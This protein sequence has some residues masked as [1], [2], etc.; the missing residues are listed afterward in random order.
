MSLAIQIVDLIKAK[1]EKG[2]ELL[3]DNY[4][5]ALYGI[6]FRVLNNHSYAEEA[7][8]NSFLKVWKNIQQYDE[9]KATLYTWMSQIVRYSSLDIRRLKSFE[10]QEKTESLEPHVNHGKATSTSTDALDAKKIL[11]GLEEKYSIILEYLYLKGYTQ[12]ELSDELDIPLGTIK[13]RLRKA[14]TIIRT[15]LKD[16]KKLFMGMFLLLVL[17]VLVKIFIF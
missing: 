15:N 7:L 14:I 17:V 12:Q 4:S 10:R 11:N 16:E 6:A 13:T 5:K 1:D 8:Q 3:Y 2:L 9:N